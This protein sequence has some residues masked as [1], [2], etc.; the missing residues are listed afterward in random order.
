MPRHGVTPHQ[1]PH[2]LLLPEFTIQLLSNHGRL[3]D[4]GDAVALGV[5]AIK[6]Q[7]QWLLPLP[8]P[9]LWRPI[10]LTKH[11][12]V[13]RTRIGNRACWR[14]Y[15]LENEHSSDKEKRE[16][17][18]HWCSLATKWNIMKAHTHRQENLNNNPKFTEPVTRT[19][20]SHLI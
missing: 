11:L 18:E 12:W 19:N 20:R 2:Q 14:R 17:D 3:S 7:I 9:I 15:T 5:L 10:A 8:S 16:E 6:F 4:S 1:L 13:S